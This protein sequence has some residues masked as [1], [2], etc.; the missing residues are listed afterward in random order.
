MIF[1]N[2]TKRI[3]TSGLLLSLVFL[4]FNY[5]YILIYSLVIFSVLS[6][7]EF[8]NITKKIF[9]KKFYFYAL[10]L[11]F[12]LYIFLFSFFFVYFASFLQLKIILF[13]LLGCCIASDIGGFIFGKFF[14]GPK[15]TKISPNKTYAGSIGSLILSCLVISMSMYSYSKIFTIDFLIIGFFTSLACQAGDL[16]FSFLKRKS[17]IKDTGNFLPGHGGILDRV[18]GILLGVPFGFIVLI[19]LY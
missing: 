17:K 10:N 3:T 12:I 6:L 16:F 4:I 19:S 5:K 1:G 9:I 2:Y 14:K 15:L 7:L 13:S 8:V 18:D 11:I